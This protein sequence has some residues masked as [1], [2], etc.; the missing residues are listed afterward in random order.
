MSL[1]FPSDGSHFDLEQG[2][3]IHK[4]MKIKNDSPLGAKNVSIYWA[5]KIGP[6]DKPQV[7]A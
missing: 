1:S 6:C 3:L 2:D 4:F 7:I 5:F